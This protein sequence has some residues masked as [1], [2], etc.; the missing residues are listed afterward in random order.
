MPKAAYNLEKPQLFL[1][2]PWGQMKQFTSNL[3]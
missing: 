3:M 1:M 2:L